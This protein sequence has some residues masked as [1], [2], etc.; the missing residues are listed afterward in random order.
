MRKKLLFQSKIS[1]VRLG[2]RKEYFSNVFELVVETPSKKTFMPLK[3]PKNLN[4]GECC[5]LKKKVCPCLNK[6]RFWLC[7]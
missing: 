4:F 3:M 1:C 7:F 5:V 2:E 6:K